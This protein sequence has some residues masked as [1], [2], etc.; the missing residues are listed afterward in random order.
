M[1]IMRFQ[2]FIVQDC[3]YEWTPSC[4]P[5]AYWAW[6]GPRNLLRLSWDSSREYLLGPLRLELLVLALGVHTEQY[7][8]SPEPPSTDGWQQSKPQL[9]RFRTER[10]CL[11]DQTHVLVYVGSFS[12]NDAEQSILPLT[13][14]GAQS[15]GESLRLRAAKQAKASQQRVITLYLSKWFLIK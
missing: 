7:T 10:E 4:Q 15:A 2:S 13:T 6:P 12:K 11:G 9:S 5:T 14:N 3:V 1:T 8:P